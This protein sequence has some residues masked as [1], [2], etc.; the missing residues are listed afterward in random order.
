MVHVFFIRL[1]EAGPNINCKYSIIFHHKMYHV[2]IAQ[3]LVPVTNHCF[4][5]F[6][7]KTVP[8][9]LHILM[10]WFPEICV[11]SKIDDTYTIIFVT[12][13]SIMLT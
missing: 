5:F 11:F 9:M 10:V 3:L 2:F 6:L 8:G 7:F 1:R 12:Q 13:F 4:I